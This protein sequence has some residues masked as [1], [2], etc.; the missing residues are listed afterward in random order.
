MT[1]RPA[2]PEREVNLTRVAWLVS[3]AAPVVLIALLGLVKAA[4]SPAAEF[5]PPEAAAESALGEECIE[6]EEG[7]VECEPAEAPA[8]PG[9]YPPEACLL[10]SAQAR[11]VSSASRNRLRIVV[12]YSAVVPTRAYLDFEMRSGGASLGLGVVKR[13]LGRSG[14]L[15]LRESL[16]AA[17]MER[18]RQATDFL[19]TVDIPSTP[20]YCD[21]YSTRRLSLRRTLHGR[22]AWFQSDPASGPAE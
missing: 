5:P 22:P 10:R 8:E 18:A 15:R 4:S 7:V 20:S 21:R 17:Q 3:I 16:G 19:L 2:D 11:V 13:H 6:W 14:V 12:R 1:E 9:P